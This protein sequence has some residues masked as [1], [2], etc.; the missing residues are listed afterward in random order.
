[1]SSRS[2]I[3][4]KQLIEK[5]GNND[6]A[7]FTVIFSK[8]Y[9]DLVVFSYS[10]TRNQSASEEII[11]EVFLKLWENRHSQVIEKSI[12]SYLLKSVQNRSLDWLRHQKVKTIHA[13]SILDHPVLYEND[14]E[15]YILYSELQDK[16]FQ[17]LGRIPEECARPFMMN[18]FEALSYTEIAEKLGVSVRT[19]EVRIS[20]ALAYLKEGL[21]DFL[22]LLATF[23][24]MNRS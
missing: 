8:Y 1:M 10:F 19:V 23:I 21:K 20:K 22:L 2:S 3:F 15:N 16:L 12:K 17:T 13:A 6:K 14:T 7:S 5:L 11:Q 18:R 4:E 9:K 24:L